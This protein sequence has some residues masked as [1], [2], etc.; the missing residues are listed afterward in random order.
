MKAKDSVRTAFQVKDTV[1]LKGVAIL[2]VILNHIIESHGVHVPFGM[3]GVAMFLVLSGYGLN[4]SLKRNGKRRYWVKKF[5]GVYLP[6]VVLSIAMMLILEGLDYGLIV[7]DILLL[8]PYYCYGWYINF[9]ALCY[10]AFYITSF[11]PV[12]K[13]RIVAL[14]VF[15]FSILALYPVIGKL[16]GF[17]FVV[18]VIISQYPLLDR[19]GGYIWGSCMFIA[20]LGFVLFQTVFSS[21]P[22]APV[23]SLWAIGLF[24]G[25]GLALWGV[26]VICSKSD[27]LWGGVFYGIGLISYELYILHGWTIDIYRSNQT[28]PGMLI[29]LVVT[30]LLSYIYY[31]MWKYLNHR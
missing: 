19:W 5:R 20:C 30:F 15:A 4:E 9:I 16:Q 6:Y 28:W 25:I 11:I 31:R 10:I 1:I 27:S 14:T 12:Q 26:C 24:G 13:W 3:M 18:G 21:I 23:L 22:Y 8:K 2:L 29:F 17:S 7:N